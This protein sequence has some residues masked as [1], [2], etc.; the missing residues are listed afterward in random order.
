MGGAD[1]GTAVR[2]ARQKLDFQDGL[3]VKVR[4]KV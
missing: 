1:Q 4:A 3:Q 2:A